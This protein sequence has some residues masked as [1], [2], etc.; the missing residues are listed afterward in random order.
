MPEE[1]DSSLPF[2]THFTIP[3]FDSEARKNSR[4]CRHP[5]Q[6]YDE[7]RQTRR[8]TREE[9]FHRRALCVS[10][11]P[12]PTSLIRVPVTPCWMPMSHTDSYSP[13]VRPGIGRLTAV[14][15]IWPSEMH[16]SPVSIGQYVCLPGSLCGFANGHSDQDLTRRVSLDKGD[17][18]LPRRKNAKTKGPFCE[19]EEESQGP[20]K[21]RGITSS[22]WRSAWLFLDGATD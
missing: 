8:P 17:S 21:A 4:R 16:V 1:T 20:T 2:T 18:T 6:R 12:L 3:W 15:R 10:S 7:P 19:E 14:T 5:V 9:L 11:V 13:L 22:K